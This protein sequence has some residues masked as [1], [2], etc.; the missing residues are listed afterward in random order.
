MENIPFNKKKSGGG[1]QSFKK[2]RVV[3]SQIGNSRL[4]KTGIGQVVG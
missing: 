3:K 1:E 4:R 2:Q